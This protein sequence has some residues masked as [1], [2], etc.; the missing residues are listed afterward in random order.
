VGGNVGDL[1]GVFVVGVPVGFPVVNLE[2]DLVVTTSGI[3]TGEAL[4][5]VVSPKARES[6]GDDRGD[7]VI[8]T[9]AKAGSLLGEVVGRCMGEGVGT[10]GFV[11]ET[12]ASLG[13]DLGFCVGESEGVFGTVIG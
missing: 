7:F 8:L 5:N 3:L 12:G 9:G 10:F 11:T 1:V 13:A 2:G 6:V 4:G